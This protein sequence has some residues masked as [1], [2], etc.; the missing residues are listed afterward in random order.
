MVVILAGTKTQLQDEH[1]PVELG[2][3]LFVSAQQNRNHTK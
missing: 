3:Q 1:S 2:F